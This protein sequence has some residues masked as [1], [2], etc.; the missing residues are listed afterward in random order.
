MEKYAA[1]AV[2]VVEAVA[3]PAILIKTGKVDKK[4][5]RQRVR[6]KHVNSSHMHNSDWPSSSGRQKLYEKVGFRLLW[7][8]REKASQ[9]DKGERQEFSPLSVS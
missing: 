3:E 8:F 9:K 2:E 6:K 1:A 4:V 7:I 5:H